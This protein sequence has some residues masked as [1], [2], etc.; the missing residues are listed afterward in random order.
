MTGVQTCALPIFA[1][2]EALKND[3][4]HTAAVRQVLQARRQTSE[5]P[6]PIG[7]A[8]PDDERVRNAHVK[9]HDLSDY[10]LDNEEGRDD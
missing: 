7:I 8:L 6:P 9:P 3:T 5:Q 4:L 2:C 1:I 10:D